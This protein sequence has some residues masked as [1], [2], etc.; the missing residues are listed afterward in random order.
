MRNW[1]GLL[2]SVV[3]TV[4]KVCYEMSVEC[5]HEFGD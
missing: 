2:G 3:S 1:N 5:V 4:W